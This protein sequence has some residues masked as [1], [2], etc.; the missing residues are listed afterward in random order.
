MNLDD[1][2]EQLQQ[3]NEIVRYAAA[4]AGAL[5]VVGAVVGGFGG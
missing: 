1:S 2:W 3:A 5:V 4:K